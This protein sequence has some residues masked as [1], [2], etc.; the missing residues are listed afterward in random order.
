MNF[1][2]FFWE[3]EKSITSLLIINFLFSLFAAVLLLG[4][5]YISGSDFML[6]LGWNLYLAWVPLLVATAI[7]FLHRLQCLNKMSLLVLGA[8]WLLFLPNAPY[9]VTDLVHLKARPNIPFWYDSILL[10]VFLFQGLYLG[11]WSMRIMHN[12]INE[13]WNKWMGWI[14]IISTLCL[15]G[16][17]I[18]LGRCLRWNCWVLFTVFPSLMYDIAHRLVA[19]FDHPRTYGVTLMFGFFMLLGYLLLMT[20]PQF[21]AVEKE[22]RTK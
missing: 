9:L 6:F 15:G 1:I 3:R 4:R 19:P 17:G 8:I 14:T 18:C 2:Q 5:T 16:F 7:Y 22:E 10:S 13:Y 12:I 21:L 11:F 20:L